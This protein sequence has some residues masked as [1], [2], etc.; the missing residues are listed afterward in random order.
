V[1]ATVHEYK[2]RGR[3]R[4]NGI[5]AEKSFFFPYVGICIP[6]LAC[7]LHDRWCNEPE[8]GKLLQTGTF[9]I[10]TH[11]HTERDIRRER[12]RALHHDLVTNVYSRLY[13][14]DKHS[15][16]VT[17]QYQ[18]GGLEK[19]LSPTPTSRSLPPRRNQ[20]G[21]NKKLWI[22]YPSEYSKVKM[23]PRQSPEK[24][25]SERLGYIRTFV[26]ILRW[27]RKVVWFHSTSFPYT[28]WPVLFSYSS[29]QKVRGETR[30]ST[31][32]FYRGTK[33]TRIGVSWRRK[34]GVDQDQKESHR[35]EF[36]M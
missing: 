31:L 6:R 15:L 30:E 32:V 23:M 25:R 3:W 21:Q 29:R 33:E 28:L 8:K 26:A 24:K 1:Y 35:P 5:K 2:R 9:F 14:R 12:M 20:K 27:I 10:V 22:Y 11:T 16:R 19:H 4:E 18:L 36:R 13:Y 17:R 34:I 7:V